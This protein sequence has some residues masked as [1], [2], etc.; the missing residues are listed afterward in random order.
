MTNPLTALQS[1]A[2]PTQI[3][4]CSCNSANDAVFVML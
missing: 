3:A 1:I 2:A 4:D